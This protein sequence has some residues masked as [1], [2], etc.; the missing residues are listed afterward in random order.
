MRRKREANHKERRTWGPRLKSKNQ[1]MK[2][3][4]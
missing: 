2:H 3:S 1:N 4:K